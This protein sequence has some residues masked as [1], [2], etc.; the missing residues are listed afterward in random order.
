VV[1]NI[2]VDLTTKSGDLLEGMDSTNDNSHFTMKDGGVTDMQR[3][4]VAEPS[5]K[6][7]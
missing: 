1:L 2:N 6:P 3:T 5:I 4:C 7:S